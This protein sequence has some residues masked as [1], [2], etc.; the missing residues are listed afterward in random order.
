MSQLERSVK[1]WIESGCG[2][3]VVAVVEDWSPV[4]SFPGYN[5]RRDGRPVV[6]IK[7]AG[8]MCE[9]MFYGEFDTPEAA[10]RSANAVNGWIT[11]Y[12]DKHAQKA[13]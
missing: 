5:P 2:M 9:G 7:Y 13:A 6:F 8:H 10:Q 12:N 3:P 11:R 1:G 4:K